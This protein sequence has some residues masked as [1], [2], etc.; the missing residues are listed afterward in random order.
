ML[1]C[2]SRIFACAL[3]AAVC[4][5]PVVASADGLGDLR[6]KP[7]DGAQVKLDDK[8]PLTWNVLQ[9]D[10][11]KLS[12]LVLV[13]LGRRYL[14]LDT[15]AKLIYAIFPNDVHRDGQDLTSGD[16]AVKPHIIPSTGWTERDIGPAEE[17]RLVLGDYGRTLSVQLPHPLDIRLG[18][19]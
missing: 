15:K 13:L 9:P 10:K 12:N 17:F 8:V 14:L 3:L 2:A 7:V 6:W 18:V 4:L 19:Y 11:K 1:A 16:I 5:A